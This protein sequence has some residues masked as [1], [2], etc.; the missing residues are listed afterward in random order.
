FNKEC[1]LRY[2][3]AALDPNL[4]LYQRIAKIV[5]IDDDC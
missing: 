4:N 2:K 5:S 1:L 3:E